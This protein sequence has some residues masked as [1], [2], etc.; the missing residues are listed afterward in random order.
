M[1]GIN[2]KD[3]WARTAKTFVQAFVAAVPVSAIVASVQN[4]DWSALGQ[5]AT[6]GTLAGVAAVLAFVWN[7][8]LEW[9]KTEA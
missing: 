3:V 5:L 1:E 4:L 9:T 6:A 2:W 7:T 8:L